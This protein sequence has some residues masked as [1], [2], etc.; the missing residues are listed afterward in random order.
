MKCQ[1]CNGMRFVLVERPKRWYQSGTSAVVGTHKVNEPCEDCQATG[2][3]VDP[4]R[5][6]DCGMCHGRGERNAWDMDEY[7]VEQCDCENPSLRI[8][9]SEKPAHPIEA[10][11]LA[12]LE[13]S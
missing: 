4:A 6:P 5:D 11:L 8:V 1:T 7:T 12:R 10:E 2:L 13:A 9:R 3:A